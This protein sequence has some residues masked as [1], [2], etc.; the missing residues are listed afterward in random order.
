MTASTRLWSSGDCGR[1]SVPRMFLTC[2]STVCSVTNSRSAIA[3]FERPSAIRASTSRSRSVRRSS[4]LSPCRRRPT[5]S[6]TTAGSRTEPP[7]PDAVD[8]G[9][10]LVEVGHALLEQV[11]DAVGPGGEQFERVAGVDVLGEDEDS[12]RGPSLAD[13]LGRAQSL[14]GV[15]RWH[16]DVDDRDVR[17]GA[18]DQL[19]Q[20]VAVGGEPDDFEAGFF[21]QPGEAFAQDDRVVGQRYAHGIS[22]RS[23]VPRPGGLEIVNRPP[24]ASMRSASPR[25][26][27][28]PVGVAPPMPSSPTSMRQALTSVGGEHSDLAGRGSA[29]RR[30]S[31]PR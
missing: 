14:V 17:A 16:P 21:E 1:R 15:R 4:G 10:E 30:W 25:S 23:V 13:D 28:P 18:L 29:W 20:A 9:G 8:A 12:D 5:S 2:F 24:S 11:A 19:E 27:E 7:C 26:P 6:P 3:W 22:A 31:A